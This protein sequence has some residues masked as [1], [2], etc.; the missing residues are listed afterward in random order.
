MPEKLQLQLLPQ[1]NKILP[2]RIQLNNDKT[3][4]NLLLPHA[5]H[6]CLAQLNQESILGQTS[7]HH[8]RTPDKTSCT[9]ALYSRKPF[10]MKECML[11]ASTSDQHGLPSVQQL[12]K[13]GYPIQCTRLRMQGS[14][15][16]KYKSRCM[17]TCFVHALFLP[18][19][20]HFC[21]GCEPL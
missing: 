4:C 19:I 7:S 8:N 11:V 2:K 1:G 6:C 12:M 15:G 21:A 17:C 20:T 10:M 3:A 5:V 18:H 9:S 13:A 16:S 14:R